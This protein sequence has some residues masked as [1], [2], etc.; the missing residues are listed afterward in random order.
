M[1]PDFGK[2]RTTCSGV[3]ALFRPTFSLYSCYLYFFLSVNSI[4]KPT[5]LHGWK[6]NHKHTIHFLFCSHIRRNLPLQAPLWKVQ[7]SNSDWFGL[8]TYP[9][10]WGCMGLIGRLFKHGGLWLAAPHKQCGWDK[11][12]LK[13]SDSVSRSREGELIR[14]KQH[15]LQSYMM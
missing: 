3:E 10:S 4:L 9:L 2:G 12:L 8:I 14:H 7:R 5:F 1:K 13:R 15:W 6:Y 11:Q